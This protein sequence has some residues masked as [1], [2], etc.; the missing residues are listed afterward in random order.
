MQLFN[1]LE[2]LV[3]LLAFTAVYGQSIGTQSKNWNPIWHWTL[4]IN[5]ENIQFNNITYDTRTIPARSNSI[6]PEQ[7]YQSHYSYSSKMAEWFKSQPS[8]SEAE[9][10][11]TTIIETRFYETIYSRGSGITY[12]DCDGIPRFRFTGSPTLISSSMIA[13]TTTY[14]SRRIQNSLLSK[15][16]PEAPS[17]NL[18]EQFCG[19]QWNEFFVRAPVGIDNVFERPDPVKCP[20][21]RVCS[22]EIEGEVN[23]MFF[24]PRTLISRDICAEDGLGT[25]RTLTATERNSPGPV[26][27]TEVTF[28]PPSLYLRSS[29]RIAIFGNAT[30]SYSEIVTPQG[31][32]DTPQ[33]MTGS[34][35]FEHNNVYL[36]H[37][38]ISVKITPWGSSTA[39]IKR[40]L[41][42]S[43][44]ISLAPEQLYLV[45]PF[46]RNINNGIEYARLVAEGLFEPYPH[47]L[48]EPYADNIQPFDYGHLQNPVPA[49][50]YF[51]ARSDDCWGKQ[52]HCDTITDDT[53]KPQLAI[54]SEIW[55]SIL[56]DYSDCAVPRIIDP[57]VYLAPVESFDLPMPV[58]SHFT[59]ADSSRPTRP[60]VPGSR[61]N[62]PLALPTTATAGRRYGGKP[63]TDQD[64]KDGSDSNVRQGIGFGK[65]R[66]GIIWRIGQ[67]IGNPNTYAMRITRGKDSYETLRDELRTLTGHY[68]DKP[69]LSGT[70]IRP[71]VQSGEATKALPYFLR[72]YVG[73][74]TSVTGWLLGN[75]L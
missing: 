58:L 48:G 40:T 17:C 34:F 29:K 14:H 1:R 56:P 3:S 25:A 66:E 33:V 16:L 15:Y 6:G 30:S 53:Y 62:L 36:A 20:Q 28:E 73:V 44:I 2:V 27:T 67:L 49:R 8:E 61:P 38:H 7:C 72:L 50:L 24:L 41:S 4:I 69:G 71:R 65:G 52:S 51:D 45:R 12:R 26:T 63:S 75:L 59:T 31:I 13:V 23:L 64:H 11:T 37:R 55:H 22:L 74:I 68:D 19:Q 57:P 42:G 60:A 46:D 70:T 43:G 47:E 9:P 54:E 5:P 32:Y 10:L 39:E 35:I 21:R 18:D